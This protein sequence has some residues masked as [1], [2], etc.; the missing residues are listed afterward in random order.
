MYELGICHSFGKPTIILTDEQ[1]NIPFDINQVNYLR[2]ALPENE[3]SS[4]LEDTANKIGAV[5]EKLSSNRLAAGNPVS[6][7]LPDFLNYAFP[8]NPRDIL[9]DAAE[10]IEKHSQQCQS[11]ANEIV[12]IA[13]RVA[14]ARLPSEGFLQ[15][16]RK[17]YQQFLLVFS[18]WILMNMSYQHL[19]NYNQDF[20]S[21]GSALDSFGK[22]SYALATHNQ[23]LA[24]TKASIR[25][26]L[27]TMVV[28]QTS[29]EKVIKNIGI[30]IEEVHKGGFWRDHFPGIL[31][32]AGSAVS[33][34]SMVTFLVLLLGPFTESRQPGVWTAELEETKRLCEFLKQKSE[35]ASEL[36]NLE[37]SIEKKLAG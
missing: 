24:S 11:Y 34:S 20:E 27:T 28:M 7:V 31:K 2:F 17:R 4:D 19:R 16:V 9:Q 25:R 15:S 1:Q 35:L 10:R 13:K 18:K 6:A 23:E 8:I 29:I 3:S 26:C 22:A 36:V 14:T 33:P 21:F 12:E 5:A 30:L 32:I 37:A